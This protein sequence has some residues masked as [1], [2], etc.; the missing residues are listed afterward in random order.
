MIAESSFESGS[1]SSPIWG[2]ARQRLRTLAR[3]PA[4]RLDVGIATALLAVLFAPALMSWWRAWTVP[5]WVQNYAVFII[6]LTLLWLWINRLRLVIPELDELNAQYTEASV[7]R[8][9]QEEE[10]EPP[11]RL[12]WPL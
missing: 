4:A 10:P 6:P 7:L 2:Y 12:R 8:Y 11:K 1:P 9:L 5:G 3:D